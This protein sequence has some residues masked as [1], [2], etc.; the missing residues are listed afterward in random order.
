MSL[1]PSGGGLR[2]DELLI[3]GIVDFDC[4][5]YGCCCSRVY[6]EAVTLVDLVGD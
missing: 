3:A 5:C 4:G 1:K 6:G 2:F